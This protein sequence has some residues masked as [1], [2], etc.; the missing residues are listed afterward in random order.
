M[1][2][3]AVIVAAILTAAVVIGGAVAWISHEEHERASWTSALK[4][5]LQSG[6]IIEG[7]SYGT[8]RDE[9]MAEQRKNLRVVLEKTK[10][11]VDPFLWDRAKATL[12][13]ME[14]SK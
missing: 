13:D 1:K 3:F 14:R 11:K 6:E 5:C 12:A 2:L 7:M 9:L 4:S 10:G 8:R